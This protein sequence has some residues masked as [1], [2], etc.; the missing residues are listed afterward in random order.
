M[1]VIYV[2]LPRAGFS[3]NGREWIANAVVSTSIGVCTFVVYANMTR[4]LTLTLTLTLA[5]ALTLT[6]P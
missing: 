6:L 1:P 5:L 4:T 2:C 3:K